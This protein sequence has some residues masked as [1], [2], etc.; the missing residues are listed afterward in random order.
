MATPDGSFVLMGGYDGS[1]R[2][3]TW[4]S[5]DKG[6]TWNLKNASSGW[7]ARYLMS[8]VTMQDGSIILMSGFD[9]SPYANDVWRSTDKGVTWTQ[10]TATAAW[11]G[12][13]WHSSVA[14][15][16]D[17]IVLMGGANSGG[18]RNDV[19]RSTNYGATWTQQ[20]ATAEWSGRG[21]HSSVAMPDGSIVLMG[22]YDGSNYLNDTWISTNYG[23]S[24]TQVNASS[25]WSARA[26][27]SSV[28]M[29]DGSILLMGGYNTGGSVVYNDVWRST[30]NG[31]TWTQV[32][33][34]SGWSVRA[35]H[36]SVAMPDGSILLMAGGYNDTWRFDPTGSSL[37][38]PSHTYTTPGT[39]SVALQAYN[40]GGYNSTIKA[41]YITA[42]TT[43]PTTGSIL[44]TSTPAS[45]AIT[46]DD[47]PLGQVTSYTAT[48]LWSGYHHVNVTLAGYHPQE[49]SVYV[50]GG[51]T[52]PVDFTLDPIATPT[53]SIEVTSNI[54]GAAISIDGVDKGHVTNYT[55]N[56]YLG[57]HLVTLT[58]PGYFNAS[59]QVT[60]TSGT[61][62]TATIIMSPIPPAYMG[63][64]LEDVQLVLKQELN[65]DTS[66]KTAASSPEP[67]PP[68][69]VLTLWG[70]QSDIITPPSPSTIVFIDDQPGANWEHPVR[71]VFIDSYGQKTVINAMSP[72]PEL[73]GVIEQV[74]G[75]I[76]QPAGENLNS[77]GSG[78]TPSTGG[79]LGY[80]NLL[81]A[82]TS[83]DCS[84]NYAVLIDGGYDYQNNHIRYWNDISFMYQTLNQTYG[85]PTDHIRVY[86]SDGTSTGTDRHRWTNADGTKLYDSSPTS[87]DGNRY[88]NE[89][90]GDARNATVYSALSNLGT[91]FTNKDIFIFTTGH[92]GW[93]AKRGESFL[94]G[95]NKDIMFAS[96]FV[97]KLPP[98]AKSITLVMEQCNSGGFVNKF[99]SNI[100]TGQKRMIATASAYNQPS[101]DNGFSSTWT[102]AAAKID[103]N[104]RAALLADTPAGAGDGK[105]SVY[106]ASMY[107]RANDPYKAVE[108][109]QYKESPASTGQ[110]QFLHLCSAVAPMLR[111]TSPSGGETWSM[112]WPRTISWGETGLDGTT[113]TIDLYKGST[114]L[115]PLAT[116]LNPKTGSF[117]WTPARTLAAGTDYVIKITSAS[118]VKSDQKSLALIA[119]SATPGTFQV[120]SK[121]TGAAVF[122]DGSGTSRGVTPASGS[123][124]IA[125][126]APGSHTIKL[127][128]AGY[129]D[130]E[131]RYS[132]A[133]GKTTTVSVVLQKTGT[134]GAGTMEITSSPVSSQVIINGAGTGMMT[135]YTLQLDPGTYAVTVQAFGFRNPAAQTLRV[136]NGQQ[137]SQ[138]FVLTPGD[139]H[140]AV[141]RG[142][143]ASM[144]W[145]FDT[146]MDGV[147]EK[148]DAFGLHVDLP[149][150]ADFNRDGI[151]DRAVFRGT[152][153]VNNWIIDYSMDGGVD[154]RDTFG[155][156]GDIPLAGDF[157]KDGIM[158][159][160]VFRSVTKGNNWFIDYSMDGSI[161]YQDRYGQIGDIP[162]VGDFNKDGITDRAV[163]REITKV[164][165]WIID[166]NMD[167]GVD[168]RDTFGSIGDIPLVGDFNK[169]GIM[170]RAVFRGKTKVNNWIIDYNMDG[171]VDKRD[172]FGQIGD[173]P[174]MWNA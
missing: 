36:S 75:P 26:G 150:T 128:L 146:N 103:S 14:M 85:Y 7:S 49:K 2:N 172:T 20:T 62:T 154:K 171:G 105:I 18:R 133:S 130:N 66:V 165:N 50:Q 56:G 162:V 83:K 141:F 108:T 173:I 54:T 129:N 123:L 100:P 101:N 166:Y 69:Q 116:G 127:K 122:V 98:N 31:M 143:N 59:Q 161:D 96:D 91:L 82:C 106:E 41:G 74:A 137:V 33:A 114:K 160:A 144:N 57:E 121:P 68:S 95:W 93:D 168:K 136:F 119:Y 139:T 46:L 17:S 10:R 47:I 9:G 158:D 135:P 61:T 6:V 120:S 64:V 167:G 79:G 71:Y 39:Y 43:A 5:T 70:V 92:G 52:T 152:T 156:I 53:G 174:V 23:A 29:P 126:M 131:S 27:H 134:N 125:G 109:P 148:Q 28:A 8:S 63:Q 1:F 84:N 140:R 16:D 118:P 89:V 65:D 3:D 113:L 155:K 35:G 86:M 58:Y 77:I 22:G 45:A 145:L 73:A 4:L 97:S 164:N 25:G 149:L 11:S 163:F 72:S 67:L 90:S 102:M 157:N 51:V 117:S 60:V 169:D 13:V 99:M 44:I 104:M 80:L 76:Y 112:G 81:P 87:F 151:M 12:R 153:K 40:I 24:W 94:Y 32:N 159:R 55:F 110:S 170:D 88:G 138:E 19:W 147:V 34:S 48:S 78:S 30:D 115:T 142:R 124:N 37:Q 15:P 38:D 21:D 132:V 42:T 111:L 107:A